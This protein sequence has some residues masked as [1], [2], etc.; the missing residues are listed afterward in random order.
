MINDYFKSSDFTAECNS[1]YVIKGEMISI[2]LPQHCNIGDYLKIHATEDSCFR[3]LQHNGQRIKTRRFNIKRHST[4][5]TKIGPK[6]YVESGEPRNSLEL[7]CIK[8]DSEWYA[9]VML[10]EFKFK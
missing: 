5:K 3:I 9:T 2:T 8:K 1:T 7:V 10:G 4:V 6:G